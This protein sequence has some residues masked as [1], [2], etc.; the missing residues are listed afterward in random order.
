MATSTAMAKKRADYGVGRS[1]FL[2]AV[3]ETIAVALK[4]RPKM[5]GS[6]WFLENMRFSRQGKA[7]YLIPY[8]AGW[9]DAMTDPRVRQVSLM[10]SARV[11]K[12]AA[13]LGAMAY[14]M[15]YDPSAILFFQPSADDAKDFVKKEVMPLFRNMPV[16][17]GLKAP[18]KRGRETDT[19]Q[20]IYLLNG[21]SAS[22]RGAAA[23][24]AFRRQNTRKNFADEIDADGFEPGAGG[25][26]IKRLKTRGQQEVGAT[27][28]VAST[29]T[30][31]GSSRIE[32][33]FEKGDQREY[34]VPCPLCGETQTLEWGD[35]QDWG[36]KAYRDEYGR[37][38]RATYVCACC[39]GEI[40]EHHKRSMLE[41]GEWIAKKEFNGHASFHLNTLYSM[42]PNATWK[43]L[44]EEWFEAV[45]SPD[46]LQPFVNEVLGEPWEDRA[47]DIVQPNVLAARCET[48]L[49]ECPE[50]VAA[51]TFGADTQGENNGKLKGWGQIEIVGWGRGEESWS[52]GA[53]VINLDPSEPEYW[54]EVQRIIDKPW[55]TPSGR[56]L[57]PVAGCIDMGGHYADDVKAFCRRQ[58]GRLHNKVWPVKGSSERKGTRAPIIPST[59]SRKGADVWMIVGTNSAKDRI[60]R[61]LKNDVPGTPGYMHFPKQLIDEIPD[62]FEQMTAEKKLRVRGGSG[63]Y[64]DC[65]SGRRNEALDCR[66]Y[67]YAAMKAVFALVMKG[68]TIDTLA[69]R[70]KLPFSAPPS[71]EQ[72]VNESSDSGDDDGGA[73]AGPSHEPP[74]PPKQAP[75]QP[76]PRQRP[77]FQVAYSSVIRR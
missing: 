8:Q 42:A 68:G 53:H 15:E 40:E 63:T 25:D 3:C 43:L 48:Y 35:G 39:G 67:A 18:I 54:D 45:K 2:D 73:G 16:L 50:E 66:V 57:Y 26:K 74:E 5:T 11:G 58:R 22:F 17:R 4:P 19:A 36:I 34:W 55:T 33:E 12:T 38:T 64:W 46:G 75:P 47:S 59:P 6:Q 72:N 76:R 30:T 7:A 77:G 9:L 71:E 49:S 13:M 20:D 23:E 51:I 24:D 65:P 60:D 21:A 69:E 56:V 70:L 52:L 37:V 1:R 31:K 62:F 61:Y 29:P 10:T 41:N 14:Y 44:A 27:M 28:I 32:Q